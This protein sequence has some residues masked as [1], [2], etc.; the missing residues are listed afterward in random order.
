MSAPNF[1]LDPDI[2][3][4]LASGERRPKS[5]KPMVGL[6]GPIEK[7]TP[8]ELQIIQDFGARLIRQES[9]T[10]SFHVRSSGTAYIAIFDKLENG[11][12]LRKRHT[13]IKE[14]L[15]SPT[16]PKAIE[17]L[18]KA[19]NLAIIADAAPSSLPYRARPASRP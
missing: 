10:L 5:L 13:W 1:T 2:V 14:N 12:W 4:I 9:E 3:A 18:S 8:D 17:A 15:Y 19:Y 7:Y 11:S 16:L 6:Y